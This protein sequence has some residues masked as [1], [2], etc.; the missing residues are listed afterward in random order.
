MS[1]S[2]S[3]LKSS[4]FRRKSR[5]AWPSARDEGREVEALGRA[6]ACVH[7][8]LARREH[9]R[10]GGLGAREQECGGARQ[11]VAGQHERDGET[12]IRPDVRAADEP[13]AVAH[14]K[15]EGE[16]VLAALAVERRERAVRVAAG[17]RARELARSSR[18][19]PR[20]IRRRAGAPRARAPGARAECPRAAPPSPA[21]AASAALRASKRAPGGSPAS[22]ALPARSRPRARG[23]AASASRTG[24]RARRRA[25]GGSDLGRV[26]GTG[27]AV[28]ARILRPELRIGEGPG[29]L[30]RGP[31]RAD[32]Q[33]RWDT[34]S[35]AWI[36]P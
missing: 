14:R 28:P 2:T 20:P 5:E 24:R 12:A 23:T 21:G 16:V 10:A 17:E 35:S 26:D 18:P 30:N 6:H 1:S 25:M 7:E 9:G 33:A 19:A 8:L 27:S 29:G 11:R 22:G 4:L 36:R 34:R 32:T 15:R 3:P 13:R 31:P